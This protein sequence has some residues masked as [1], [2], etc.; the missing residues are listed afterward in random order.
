VKVHVAKKL[1]L[2]NFVIFMS[3]GSF[4]GAFKLKGARKPPKYILDSLNKFF[5]VLTYKLFNFLPPYKKVDDKIEMVFGLVLPSKSPYKLN[6]KK[7]K[8]LKK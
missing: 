6:Q 2:P 8:E 1:E 7:L 3:L 4:N 5:K